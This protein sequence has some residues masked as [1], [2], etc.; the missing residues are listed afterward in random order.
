LDQ[1][2]SNV[3]KT[4]VLYKFVLDS[5]L[6]CSYSKWRRH[7]GDRTSKTTSKPCTF[8]PSLKFVEAIGQCVDAFSSS[9]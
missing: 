1:T 3:G 7:K 4:S 2:G 8:W 5:R 9:G 6:N